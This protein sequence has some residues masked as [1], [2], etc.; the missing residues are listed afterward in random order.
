MYPL[1]RSTAVTIPVFAH[2][3]NGDAVNSIADGSF[4]K[5]ISK[6]GGAF[7]A[8]TVTITF[9]ENGW[10]SVPLSTAHTDTDGVLTVTLTASGIKQ[11]NLQWKVSIAGDE[12]NVTHI[13]G[14]ATSGNNA[15]LNLKQL[16]VVN[17]AGTA[18]VASSTGSNGHGIA[19]SGNGSGEGLKATGGATGH[20]VEVVGGATSGNGV[21]IT[22]LGGSGLYVEGFSDAATFNGGAGAEAHGISIYAGNNGDGIRIVGDDIGHGLNVQG[23]PTGHGAQ[24]IGG[25][26]SGDGI[27]AT[28]TAGSKALGDAAVDAILDR[29]VTEPASVFTWPASLRT[30]AQF[31]GALA[32]NKITQTSTTQ[33]LRN[34]ADSGTI[35]TS[36]QSDDGTTFTRSEFS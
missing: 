18:I 20:G 28:A 33:T 23:G 5:R 19:A 8:M 34:D 9:M 22:S 27:R 13:D 35:A 4:T 7:A 2:D 15:T 6:N 25:A 1:K 24:F 32:R 26:T 16:N 21:A 14:L 3:V 31:L 29:A 12:A 36:T 11:I 17:S 10:Y 30:I